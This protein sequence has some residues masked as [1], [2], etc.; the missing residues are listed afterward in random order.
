M[1]GDWTWTN[2]QKCIEQMTK[3]VDSD[4]EIDTYGLPV[5][6]LTWCRMV[7]DWKMDESGKLV[8]RIDE[9][10][11]QDFFQFKYDTITVKK[12][13]QNPGKHQIQKN[14]TYPMCAMQLSDCEPYNFEHMYQSIPNGDELEVVPVP[15][16]DGSGEKKNFLQ[17]TQA[18]C[19]LAASADE[20]EAAVDLMAYLLQ[21]GMKYV[22]DFSLGSVKCDYPGI[23]G[24]SAL[25]KQWKD[26]FAGV[27][28]KRAADKAEL[29]ETYDQALID[30]IYASFEG[31][32]WYTYQT[33]SGVSLLTSY[34]EITK[35]PPAS[36]IP[37]IKEKYQAALDKFNSTYIK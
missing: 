11:M 6:S 2:F 16:Y 29:G 34:S 14:V 26:A 12:V 7:N 18:C 15:A 25:S 32:E 33:F 31:A 30:K 27:V 23:Q 8:S 20:R 3:D 37:A 13:I 36:S 35:L 19:S 21:C 22:S 28:A 10:M 1:E 4:G 9:Q 17:W 24:T 5:D